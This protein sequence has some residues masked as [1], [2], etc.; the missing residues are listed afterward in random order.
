MDEL[1]EDIRQNLQSGYDKRCEQEVNEQIFK[2]L[3]A[4]TEFEVPDAM[5]EFELEGI[6]SEAERSF[7]YRNVTMEDLGLTREGLAEKYRPT[8]EKQVRRHLILNKIVDQENLTLSDDD[9]EQGFKDMAKTY[10]Q[11]V[12]LIKN[13][14]EHN[15]DKLEYFKHTLLEKQAIKLIM[16]NSLLEEVEPELE[17]DSPPE[18]VD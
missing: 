15:Q 13:Y 17:Q 2:G 3:L 5:V 4:K 1:R 12:D 14:Y 7:E 16:E 10:N 6:L 18:K 8:A 11:T 9:L